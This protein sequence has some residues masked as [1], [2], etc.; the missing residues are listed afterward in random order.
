MTERP[1]HGS[2]RPGGR[3]A[4]IRA[5][6]LAAALDELDAAGYAAL[7]LDKLAARSG[8]HV[9]TIRRRWRTVGGVIADLLAQHSTTIPLPDSGDLRQDLHELAQA[10][11]DFH[12]VRRNRNL[13]E[14]VVAAAAQDPHISDIVR[15]SFTAGIEH[16]TQLVRR[17]VDRGE[18]LPHTDANEV[19]AALSAPFYYRLI[20]LRSLIDARLVHTSAEA[21]YRAARAGVFGMPTREPQPGSPDRCYGTEADCM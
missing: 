5:S 3:T 19:I 17:A 10:I 13:I 14:A 2:A 16:V 15:G 9:S 7:T 12:A 4:R 1:S 20:I 8:V 21:A 6:V 11:A 18:L